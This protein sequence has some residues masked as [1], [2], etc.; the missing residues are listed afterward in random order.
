ME[1]LFGCTAQS[2]LT[3]RGYF[4]TDP[5]TLDWDASRENMGSGKFTL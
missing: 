4:M 1:V 5:P 3:A 2:E